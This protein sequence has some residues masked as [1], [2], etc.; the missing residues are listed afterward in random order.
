MA[1]IENKKRSL[2]FVNI[3]ISAVATSMLATAMTTAL[4]PVTEYFGVSITTGQWLTSGFSLAQAIVMP[5]TAF[6]ITKY[7][8]RKLYLS[9]MR[10]FW[11]GSW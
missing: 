2:I 1:E 8:T 10:A 6:L 5:L 7:P 9:G 11:R 4:P 3:M